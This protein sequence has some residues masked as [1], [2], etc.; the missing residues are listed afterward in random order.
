MTTLT[1]ADF[2]DK[3]GQA[4][5]LTTPDGATLSLTLESVAGL[6]VRDFPSKTRDPFSVF[7]VGTRGVHC[8]QAIYLL[9][10][11][12]GWEVEVFLV[13]VACKTDGDYTYQGVFN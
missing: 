11:E 6:P 1:I 5:T 2:A 9:R 12:A 7:F 3:Q 8:P 4:F 10:S 13:P